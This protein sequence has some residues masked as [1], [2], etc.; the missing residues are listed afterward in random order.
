MLLFFLIS[1]SNK[2]AR[3]M[4]LPGASRHFFILIFYA[5]S[6]NSFVCKCPLPIRDFP[7]L[8]GASSWFVNTPQ[9]FFAEAA[10][11]TCASR[12]GPSVSKYKPLYQELRGPKVDMMPTKPDIQQFTNS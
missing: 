3:A 2:Q 5:M 8:R 11:K 10:P 6:T 9:E 1:S 4:P 7:L 12:K